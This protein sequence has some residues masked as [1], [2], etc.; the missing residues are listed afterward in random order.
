[1][2]PDGVVAV[3]LNAL[4]DGLGREDLLEWV[5]RVGF[6]LQAP[7][8][9]LGFGSVASSSLKADAGP[10]GG[11]KKFQGLDGCSKAYENAALARQ[12]HS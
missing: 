12:K 6:T 10:R 7:S 1:M 5:M 8:C 9:G 4:L 3:A 2:L 11:V